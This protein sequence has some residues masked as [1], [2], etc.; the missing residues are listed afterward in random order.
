MDSDSDNQVTL[1][2]AANEVEANSIVH[3]LSAAAIEA[4]VTG[5]YTSGFRTEAPG[6]INVL[7]RQAD[8]GRAQEALVQWEMNCGQTDWS[9]VD[10]GEPEGS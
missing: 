8:L 3:E 2:I 5:D 4:I 7:V 6:Q 9:N 10:V 1:I